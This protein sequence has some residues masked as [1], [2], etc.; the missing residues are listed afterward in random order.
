MARA[1]A[2]RSRRVPRRLMASGSISAAPTVRRGLSEPYGF[3]NTIWFCN[4]SV[5]S[6]AVGWPLMAMR[7][8]VGGSSR[9]HSR[10]RVDLPQ[11]DSP[12]TARVRAACSWKDTPSTAFSTRR[13][14]TG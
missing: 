6:A 14:A 5:R 12:T 10:A 7:P 8:A 2:A 11:P 9:V 13:P 1:S 4:C 3:W